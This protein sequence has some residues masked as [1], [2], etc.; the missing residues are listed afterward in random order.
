MRANL[1]FGVYRDSIRLTVVISDDYLVKQHLLG[2][3]I[4]K[5]VNIDNYKIRQLP[6]KF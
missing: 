3:L 4:A 5:I 6:N 1:C 2:C